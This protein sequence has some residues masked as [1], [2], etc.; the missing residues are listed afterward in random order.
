MPVVLPRLGLVA[1]AGAK[2]GEW[3]VDYGILV[4]PGLEDKAFWH[5]PFI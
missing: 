4:G 3:P 2:G 1:C 5:A